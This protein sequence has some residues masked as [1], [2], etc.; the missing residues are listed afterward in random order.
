MRSIMDDS[1]RQTLLNQMRALN[2]ETG[3]LLEEERKRQL[4]KESNG[5]GM[6]EVAMVLSAVGVGLLIGFYL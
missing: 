5:V 6:R 3:K 4:L 2:D 1:R